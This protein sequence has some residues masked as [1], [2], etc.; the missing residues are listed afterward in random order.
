LR[1]YHASLGVAAVL[2]IAALAVPAADALGGK[3]APH[4]AGKG[5]RSRIH[6]TQATLARAT[7]ELRRLSRRIGAGALH[8]Q[9][10]QLQ[11]TLKAARTQLTT[12]GAALDTPSPLAVANEQVRREVAY[13][14]GVG[15][16]RGQLISEAAMD[17]VAGHVSD[18]AYGYLE[19]THEKLP[20]PTANPTLSAQAGICTGA[21]LTFAAIVHHFGLPVRSVNFYYDDPPPNK[22]PDGHV[23]VEVQ[24]DGSWHFFDPTFGQFWAD[25]SGRVLSLADVRAGKGSVQKNVAA[26]TNVFEDKVFGND[27]WFITDPSTRIAYHATKLVNLGRH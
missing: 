21:A 6:T 12:A 18:T 8:E 25:A 2:A 26:F 24:Y 9:V 23:A 10:A 22:T 20:Q 5:P 19:L 11:G 15:Y 3:P 4:P 17:Y 7:S 27:A 14:E 16:S 1:L 13:T